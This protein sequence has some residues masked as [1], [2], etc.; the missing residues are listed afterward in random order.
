MDVL[1]APKVDIHHHLFLACLFPSL[2]VVDV[3]AAAQ[4]VH[5][6]RGIFGRASVQAPGGLNIVGN[7]GHGDAG[8][9]PVAGLVG[10]VEGTVT[11]LPYP[12][13]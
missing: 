8:F 1:H 5:K 10:K 12:L 11:L 13:R 7:A 3:P 6:N 4:A 2:G 9:R